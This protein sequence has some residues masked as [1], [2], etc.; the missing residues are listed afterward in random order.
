MQVRT[1]YIVR[2]NLLQ[3]NQCILPYT[4]SLDLTV[5]TASG[6]HLFAS[7]ISDTA[8][9]CSKHGIQ[10]VSLI[11]S[12]CC[13]EQSILW[14]VFCFLIEFSMCREN[15]KC[16]IFAQRDCMTH[17]CLKERF[18]IILYLILHFYSFEVT[19]MNFNII[20]LDNLLVI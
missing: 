4:N 9:A 18:V 7:L 10:V 8:N 11:V 13:D 1:W 17:P 2:Y 12:F 14:F 5:L 3:H 20:H 6:L 15:T 16:T 19:D